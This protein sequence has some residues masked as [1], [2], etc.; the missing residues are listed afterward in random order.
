MMLFSTLTWI[1]GTCE[2]AD[3]Y[4]YSDSHAE[5]L[6]RSDDK[7]YFYTS[8]YANRTLCKDSDSL[9][10]GAC[11][12]DTT[13][14]S[15][16]LDSRE[17]VWLDNNIAGGSCYCAE[18]KHC[19]A[20]DGKIAD[21][22]VTSTSFD[23]PAGCRVY[24]VGCSGK[25][26]NC[27][28]ECDTAKVLG[29]SNPVN[30]ECYSW[31]TKPPTVMPTQ[32]LATLAQSVYWGFKICCFKKNMIGSITS[33]VVVGLDLDKFLVNILSYKQISTNIRSDAPLAKEWEIVYQIGLNESDSSED[34]IARLEDSNV[35]NSIAKQI[36]ANL[37]IQLESMVTTS[38]GE[39]KRFNAL[40]PGSTKFKSVG[41]PA[42]RIIAGP[43]AVFLVAFLILCLKRW[44][45]KS[46]FFLYTA[47]KD[48]EE[49][50]LI[51]ED[52][53]YNL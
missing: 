25:Y 44:K 23:C 38:V 39:N 19:K 33:S 17:C 35:L 36:S 50:Y 26:C 45:S 41:M 53:N 28:G 22:V 43:V 2:K 11:W 32:S 24:Y 15:H 7:H 18:T 52:D 16:C 34:L 27:F 4:I 3:A 37:G 30:P 49:V 21:P 5:A 48:A 1:G 40:R 47:Q 9:D 14:E 12:W 8:Q 51:S 29:C 6:R 31:Y 20:C 46:F 42:I 10:K 13:I